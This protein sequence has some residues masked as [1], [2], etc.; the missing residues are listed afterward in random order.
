MIA[1][2]TPASTADPNPKLRQPEFTARVHPSKNPGKSS[3]PTH[4]TSMAAAIQ[5]A[6]KK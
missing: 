1:T 4:A 3:S 6:W 5:T 2:G